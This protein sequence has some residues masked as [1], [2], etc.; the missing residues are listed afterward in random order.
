MKIKIFKQLDGNLTIKAFL[1]DG[2]EVP[3]E[4]D[5]DSSLKHT[6]EVN[7]KHV[8]YRKPKVKKVVDDKT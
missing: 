6:L 2:S 7:I 5:V 4:Y 3:V 1:S 8:Y